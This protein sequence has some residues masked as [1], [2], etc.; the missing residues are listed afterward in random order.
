MRNKMKKAGAVCLVLCSPLVYSFSWQDLW[1]TA[2]QQ[3]QQLMRKGEFDQAAKR[4]QQPDW[5]AAAAYRAGHYDQSAQSFASRPNAQNYYNQGNALAH[6]Q[7]YEEAIKAYDK[8]LQLNPADQDAQR[9]I[10]V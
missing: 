10:S 8:A 3:A 2:D 1:L 6:Q 9:Q 5:Q 7:H 4:F